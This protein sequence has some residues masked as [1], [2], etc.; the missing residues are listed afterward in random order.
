MEPHFSD[1]LDAAHVES[2]VSYGTLIGVMRDST[3]NR[4]EFDNDVSVISGTPKLLPNLSL[5]ATHSTCYL[6]CT[7]VPAVCSGCMLRL[8]ALAGRA[9]CHHER[10]TDCD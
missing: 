3:L 8:Y 4:N 6:A 1:A 7:C 5:I 2:V 10:I 9:C